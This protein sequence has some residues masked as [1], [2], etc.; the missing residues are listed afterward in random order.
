LCRD[1]RVRHV[2]MRHKVTSP[3]QSHDRQ[4]WPKPRWPILCHVIRQS[5]VKKLRGDSLW[6]IFII[7]MAFLT[8]SPLIA[9]HSL[10]QSFGNH[11][12]RSLRSRSSYLPHIILR[13]MDKRKGL[14]KSWSNICIVPSTT[15]KTIGLSCYHL[16]SLR[17]TLPSKDLLSRPHSLST[18]CTTQSSISSTST[19]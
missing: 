9:V 2:T 18:M 13:L 16:P 19:K 1:K 15:I 5:Q 10:P 4:H 12:S 17:T 7:T 3:S 8:R 14:I 6:I 11:Y